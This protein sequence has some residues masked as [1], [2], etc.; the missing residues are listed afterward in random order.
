VASPEPDPDP[1]ASK[2]CCGSALVSML[3]RIHGFDDQNQQI[4]QLIKS[5]IF[6]SKNAI[7]YL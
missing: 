1:D 4:L 7:F 2:Q 5:N 6:K 3:I